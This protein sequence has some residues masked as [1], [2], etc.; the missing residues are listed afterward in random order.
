MYLLEADKPLSQSLLWQIQ[1]R[2][3]LREGVA[4]WQNDVVPSDI[5]CN[6]VMAHAYS[7]MVMA[8][9]RDWA[10]ETPLSPDEPIYMIELGAGSGRLGYHFLHQF[11]GRFA[12]SPFSK[13]QFKYILTDFAPQI[14]SFWQKHPRFQP[15]VAAGKLDFA[16]FDVADMRPLTLQHSGL[17]LTP[18]HFANPVI[19]IAN[20]FFDSIPQDSFAVTDGVL[21]QNLLS[22]YHALPSPDLDDPL[23]W[24]DLQLAYEAIPL[25]RP[26]TAAPIYNDILA[27]Y[28][29]ALPDTTITFPNIGLDCL[30][31]WQTQTN[32]RLFLLSADR[33]TTHF[34]DLAGQ[35]D[36]LPNL[37]GSFSLMVN[38]HAIGE[39]AA[40]TGGKMLH[41]PHYQDNLQVA[42]CWLGSVPNNSRESDTAFVDA[43][44]LGGPDDY[45]ALKQALTAQA[46]N[47]TLPQ[48]LSVLR[49]SRWDA[50][51]FHDCFDA[52]TQAVENSDAVW[53]GDVVEAL[54]RL[55][56][57]YLPLGE[58]DPVQLRI[59]ILLRQMDM[60]W[61]SVF[62]R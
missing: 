45:F 8:A 3:F 5:S 24:D 46:D 13:F 28:E 50:S 23:V 48:L 62:E 54:T 9:L 35:D 16:L 22:L 59:E 44:S 2:Y 47:L 17:T 1:R 42:A 41:P 27:A 61:V 26:Y 25:E 36:P 57:C 38:Y 14:V 51:L 60:D 30:H 6:P 10:A 56:R 43:I 52:L 15:W 34:N 33:G 53:Y 55:W 29:A 40:R 39:Y 19:L 58:P 18:S 11:N 31:F 37:H 4:A 49:W 7:Q 12:N 20:Y 32:G 21:C